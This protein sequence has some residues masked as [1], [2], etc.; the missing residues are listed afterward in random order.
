MIDETFHFYSTVIV[1]NM[2]VVVFIK[3]KLLKQEAKMY[4]LYINCLHNY[5]IVHVMLI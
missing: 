2:L 3:I 1:W 4:I 5:K